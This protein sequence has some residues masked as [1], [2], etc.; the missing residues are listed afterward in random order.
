MTII[1]L[2]TFVSLTAYSLSANSEWVKVDSYV[3][4]ENSTTT[5]Y[6]SKESVVGKYWIRK[7]SVMLDMTKPYEIDVGDVKKKVFSTVDVKI[8]DCMFGNAAY[9]RSFYY[10]NNK[11]N[12]EYFSSVERPEVYDYK[13]L[14]YGSESSDKVFKFVCGD[15][16]TLKDWRLFQFID[17]QAPM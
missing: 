5:V 1:K 16:F 10:D 6:V 15:L 4:Y 3:G 7:Y 12:G 2:L 17:R 8:L 9:K 13:W 14:Q 11:A